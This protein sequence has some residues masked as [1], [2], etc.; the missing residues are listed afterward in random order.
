MKCIN[1]GAENTYKER[2]ANSRRCKA[3]SHQFAFEP[4]FMYSVKFSDVFFAKLINDISA[5]NTFKFTEKQLFYLLN[6]RL[7]KK[8]PDITSELILFGF[9][10]VIVGI[11]FS[12]QTSELLIAVAGVSMV[13]SGIAI[14]DYKKNK[15]IQ[16]LLV[17]PQKFQDYLNI[18]Q[19][20]NP[21][22]GLLTLSTQRNLPSSVNSDITTYSFDR[23]VICDSAEIANLLIANNFHFENNSAV[24]SIDG[25]PENIFD[26][27]MHMLR[28]NNDLK[29][30]VL[31]DASPSGVSVV[32]TLSTNPDWFSN[33]SNSNVTIYDIGLLPRQVFN[34]SNF[35]TQISEEF[36]AQAKELS[37]EI[38]KYLI[39]EEIKWL[40]AGKYVELESFTPQKL[41]SVISQGIANSRQSASSDSFV[42][43]SG[44]GDFSGGSDACDISIF[45]D[46]CFG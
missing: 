31:H 8:Q 26:T 25:Y 45:A 22:D 14:Q 35:F 5:N 32:N 44:G 46:D 15:K 11:V 24:L 37:L 36:A 33:T 1:C 10:L 4:K 3:C 12:Q 29:I 38:K 41:L 20:V 40:E 42:D 2:I 17:T 39:N 34:N 21:I 43:Y 19:S 18:W 13:V 9:V 27:V 16:K 23:V 30:Y 6:K 28:R 7:L